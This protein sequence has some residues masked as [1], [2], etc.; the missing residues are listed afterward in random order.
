MPLNQQIDQ[1]LA[2][3]MKEGVVMRTAAL[4][5]IKNSLKNEQIKVGHELSESEELKVL[6]R[7]AKQRRDSIEQY[8]QGN[9]PELAEAEQHELDIIQEFLPQQMGEAELTKLVDDVIAEIKPTGPTQM[10]VVIG[11]VMQRAGGKADGGA[12]S[13]MVRSKLAA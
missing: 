10:G 5:L 13:Q 7:E 6:Q 8:N 12:V 9:R 1:D 11:A 4:R 2:T 3:S